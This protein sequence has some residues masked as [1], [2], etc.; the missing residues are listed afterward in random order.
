MTSA[1]MSNRRYML[2]GSARHRLPWLSFVVIQQLGQCRDG[3]RS[4]AEPLIR[5]QDLY[6]VAR[7]YLLHKT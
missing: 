5:P 1:M 3:F 2:V 4:G 6:G 7:P